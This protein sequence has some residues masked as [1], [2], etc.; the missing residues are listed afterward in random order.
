MEVSMAF[1]FWPNDP[2]ALYPAWLIQITLFWKSCPLLLWIS[3]D[4]STLKGNH[5]TSRVQIVLGCLEKQ[6][7]KE[8]GWCRT[9]LAGDDPFWKHKCQSRGSHALDLHWQTAQSA[10]SA[11]LRDQK[12][13]SLCPFTCGFF[14]PF[15]LLHVCQ[16]FLVCNNT[17]SDKC[18]GHALNCLQSLFIRLVRVFL[19]HPNYY[20]QTG[21]SYCSNR[22]PVPV[23]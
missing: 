15:I 19:K 9:L 14:P 1:L 4:C 20:S 6:C 18:K 2:K 12:R 22:F 21:L 16:L 10:G 11:S 17:S 8:R 7:Q 13:S 3:A 23:K 5:C